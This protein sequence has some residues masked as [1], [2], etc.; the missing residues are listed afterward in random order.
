MADI[1]VKKVPIEK[2]R[3]QCDPSIFTFKTTADIE[4]LREIVGQDRAL[5]AL[6][7]G[8]EIESPG[9]NIFVSG[10]TGT[11]RTTTIKSALEKF[12]E[13]GPA[14]DDI[15]YVNNYV[16]PDSPVSLLF[17]AGDGKK[18]KKAMESLIIDI[19]AAIVQRLGGQDYKNKLKNVVE[20][21]RNRQKELINRIKLRSQEE[22]FSLVQVQLS[23]N[24]IP[25]PALVPNFQN[26]P[27]SLENLEELVES[28]EFPA[29]RFEELKEKSFELNSELE[30]IQRESIR[31]E[32]ELADRIKDLEAV[33]I[34]PI[35]TGHIDTLK[36]T[37]TAPGVSDYLDSTR[38]DILEN[39]DIFKEQETPQSQQLPFPFLG[40]G[41]ERDPLWRYEVNL[42]VDN[43][44]SKGRPVI[45]ETTPSYSKLFGTFDRTVDRSGGVHTDFTKLKAGS[46][47]RANGGY[48]IVNAFDLLTEAGSWRCLKRVLIHKKIDFQCIEP[49]FL[50]ASTSLKPEPIDANIKVIMVGDQYIYNLLLAQD[51]D[52]PMIFKIK[53]DFDSVM[54]KNGDHIRH[55]ASFVK[56]VSDDESLAPFKP[57]AVSEV[58]E[59]GVREARS[60]KRMTTRLSEVADIVRESAYWAGADGAEAVDD[61]HVRK[62]LTERDNRVNMTHDKIRERIR[63][64]VLMIETEG[65]RVGQVN[66]LAV[67]SL[68]THMF[69]APSKITAVTSLGRAGVTDIEREAK[70]SGN[71]YNKGVLILSGYLRGKYARRIP[72]TLS[73]S[74]CFEQSYYG[75]DG[76]SASSTELYAIISSITDL[77]LRQDIAVTG[78]VNQKGEVQPIGGVNQKIEGFFA[79]CKD[80]GLSGTQGV[81]IPEKN[82]EDLMLSQEVVDAVK[83]GTFAVYSVSTIDE[84]IEILTG[85]AAGEAD[86]GGTY[87]EGTVNRLVVDRLMENHERLKELNKG[88]NNEK[89]AEKPE[90]AANEE[91]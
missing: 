58:V 7:T 9:Y 74:L 45:L 63:E 4:P 30:S 40:L 78:S 43:S 52:F 28:G 12:L 90:A 49:V 44:R 46:V 66:G 81:M 14:P 82:L 47:H 75:V 2:L 86:A 64:G 34:A 13:P 80:R 8:L 87:P 72:L 65:A 84:G 5:L 61:S 59:F 23:Q 37:F 51:D 57:S 48:L 17:P 83:E 60:Q 42:L 50:F 31:I 15:C 20:E 36:E 41:T 68:G 6:K 24:T 71:I 85:V 67:Y 38:D 76:D 77:P 54:E 33:E 16:N 35:V 89:E 22:G 70:L 69:G 39:I 32:R 18:F 53:S 55:Y 73:A 79:V 21:Y 3:W 91:S 1:E 26:Q 88:K 29:E 25:R 27:T 56:K 10:M 11:G 62:A 19:K